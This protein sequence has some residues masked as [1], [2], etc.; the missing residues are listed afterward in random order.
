MSIYWPS[1]H[2]YKIDSIIYMSKAKTTTLS[3]DTLLNQRVP[4]KIPKGQGNSISKTMKD[5]ISLL[6][7]VIVK[8]NIIG[9][10]WPSYQSRPPCWYSKISKTIPHP[11]PPNLYS[12]SN[13][14]WPK[15]QLRKGQPIIV[16]NKQTNIVTKCTL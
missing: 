16:V 11:T 7:L 5:Y 6:I 2:S 15:H 9:E 13:I 3:K 12:N 14:S 8:R 1:G 10:W 4:Q